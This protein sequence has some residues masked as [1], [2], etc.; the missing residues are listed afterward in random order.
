MY[1]K[2]YNNNNNIITT[3]RKFTKLD[4]NNL[5]TKSLKRKQFLSV[6]LDWKIN[7]YL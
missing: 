5:R 1:K 6:L 7:P 2:K 4:C 3:T